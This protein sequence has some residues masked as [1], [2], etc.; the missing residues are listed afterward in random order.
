MFVLNAYLLR[1][2]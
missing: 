1:E 2:L